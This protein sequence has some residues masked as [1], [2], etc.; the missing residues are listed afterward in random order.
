M[1][2]LIAFALMVCFVSEATVKAQTLGSFGVVAPTEAT[3]MVSLANNANQ[4]ILVSDLLNM[5]G[6]RAMVY[7]NKVLSGTNNTFSNIPQSA[8]TNLTTDLTGKQAADADLT[9][10]AN[11]AGATNGV[12]YYKDLTGF[13]ILQIGTGLSL[14]NGSLTSTVTGGTGGTGASYKT[15]SDLSYA[16]QLNINFDAATHPTITATGNMLFTAT[17]NN[18]GKFVFVDIR[19]ATASNIIITLDPTTLATTSLKNSTTLASVNAG[20]GTITLSGP[21]GTVY[22]I[23]LKY[24]K[25]ILRVYIENAPTEENPNPRVVTDQTFDTQGPKVANPKTTTE[26]V[27]YTYALKGGQ[28][29]NKSK[30]IF[31]CNLFQ[32]F[33]ITNAL[34]VQLKIRVNGITFEDITILKN[35]GF[36]PRTQEITMNGSVGSQTVY[37]SYH[38]TLNPSVPEV[39]RTVD[40]SQDQV[41]TFSLQQGNTTDSYW[42]GAFS[43]RGEGLGL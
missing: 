10:L 9:F 2:K 7:T 26:N 36:T 12:L 25:E 34:N 28:L 14:S 20:A 31:K 37:L 21:S 19:K 38:P 32:D 17:N 22:S 27:L 15:F 24:Q 33:T 16:S 30:L 29:T 18:N 41:I 6:P 5:T 39:T 3:K 11:A 43:I 4:N 13:K 23:L 8:V 42:L 35:T 40:F 1:K